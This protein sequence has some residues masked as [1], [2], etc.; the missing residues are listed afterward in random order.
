MDTNN[1]E[2]FQTLMCPHSVD[3]LGLVSLGILMAFRGSY[4]MCSQ[5]CL[6]FKRSRSQTDVSSEKDRG[7]ACGVAGAWVTVAGSL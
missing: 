5:S 3:W 4:G 1:T 6:C 2:V 7:E